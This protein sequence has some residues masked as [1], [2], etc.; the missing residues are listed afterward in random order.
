MS[1]ENFVI[2]GKINSVGKIDFA[3][4]GLCVYAIAGDKN[5][6]SAKISKD[7]IYEL[8]LKNKELTDNIEI[9]VVPEVLSKHANIIASVSKTISTEFFKKNLIEKLKLDL[10][11]SPDIF[12]WL[13]IIKKTYRMSGSVFST[14]FSDYYGNSVPISIEPLPMVKIE[15]YEVDYLLPSPLKVMKEEYIGEAF[16]DPDGNYTFEFTFSYRTFPYHFL[17]LNKDK[18]PDI[19]AKIYQFFNGNWTLIHEDKVD[20]NI[21][22]NYNRSYFVP[23]DKVI[24]KPS[25]YPNPLTG[26]AFVSLGLLPIDTSRFVKGYVTSMSGDPVSVSHQP[27]CGMLRIF[28]LFAKES[29]VVR[30]KAEFAKADENG[31]VINDENAESIWTQIK[32]PL[33]NS[34]WNAEIKKWLPTSLGPD[35]ENCLYSNIDMEAENE[36]HE[37]ALKITWN[38][39]NHPNG[40]YV[41][42][43]TGYNEGNKEVGAYN[44]PVICVDNKAP[45]ISLEAMRTTMG[46][47]SECGYITLNPAN[48]NLTFKIKAYDNEGHVLKYTLSGVRGK[49]GLTAGDTITVKRPDIQNN[50]N[51]ALFEEIDFIIDPLPVAISHCP[52]VAYGFV[53]RVWGSA[54]NCYSSELNSQYVSKSISLVL[55]ENP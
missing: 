50:W 38:S 52:S 47:V 31:T 29:G 48:R 4:E 9:K 23:E 27:L 16:S 10:H 15:F 43:I 12:E 18:V 5:I 33:I 19:R 3:K 54:T 21:N 45:E 28:G 40:Y 13:G 8:S 41:V 35:K 55:S 51:G 30:Y 20:W 32:D 37:H 25:T 39:A 24:V 14:K 22:T 49:D 1:S 36:W 44:M 11:I 53:L 34:K 46:N 26:F 7:G 17:L 6:S 2:T 42:R